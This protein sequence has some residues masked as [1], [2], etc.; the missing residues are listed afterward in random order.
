M[1][2][3]KSRSLSLDGGPDD[4]VYEL[5]TAVASGQVELSDIADA[6]ARWC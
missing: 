4:D 3:A 1:A 6:L 2:T 5:V